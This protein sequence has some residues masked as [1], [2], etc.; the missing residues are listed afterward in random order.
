[1]QLTLA[2]LVSTGRFT[3]CTSV[4]PEAG[5]CSDARSVTC[6]GIFRN[7]MY[8]L[9]KNTTFD[10]CRA[11]QCQIDVP[12]FCDRRQSRGQHNLSLHVARQLLRDKMQQFVR[13]LLSQLTA[14]AGG[15]TYRGCCLT[16]QDSYIFIYTCVE[17]Q[18]DMG[19]DS[20]QSLHSGLQ[21]STNCETKAY[22]HD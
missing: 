2:A 3:N 11:E 1:M 8:L 21:Q 22:K 15:S 4:R 19:M 10:L 12:R 14:C 7:W 18:A 13:Q 5:I 9:V 6:L 17:G 20:K 16:C